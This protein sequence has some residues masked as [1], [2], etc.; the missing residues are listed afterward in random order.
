MTGFVHLSIYSFE[1]GEFKVR[2]N[3]EYVAIDGRLTSTYIIKKQ[4]R[5]VKVVR[6]HGTQSYPAKLIL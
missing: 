6:L 3:V 4:Q 2:Q 5:E 1:G